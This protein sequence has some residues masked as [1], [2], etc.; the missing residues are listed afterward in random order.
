MATGGGKTV[1][2]AMLIAWQT[3]DATDQLRR[4]FNLA[5]FRR[6]LI[7]DDYDVTG[8][9]TPPFDTLLGDEL[10]NAARHNEE[11][12]RLIGAKERDLL[13]D[14]V[15]DALR[16][17]DEDPEDSDAELDLAT[18]A[19]NP[20]TFQD[21]GLSPDILMRMRGLEPPRTCIHTDLNRA[22]LPIP[23]HPQAVGSEHIARGARRLAVSARSRAL[24]RRGGPVGAFASLGARQARAAIVQGTRTPP[25]H[26]GN[27]GSN[28]GSGIH[29]K[30]LQ[31]RGSSENAQGDH[32][33]AALSLTHSERTSPAR[34]RVISRSGSTPSSR[35]SYSRTR[36]Q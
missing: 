15:D 35:A 33:P 20:G 4:Q 8:E 21:R 32:R 16:P 14:S 7:G 24:C 36:C 6:L 19:P 3:R 22:R 5:F 18:G 34:A 17:D 31:T 26:G 12:N 28:P 30:A 9:L 27:P 10:R 29:S 2:M 1:V 25:S 11:L 13:T 23:P